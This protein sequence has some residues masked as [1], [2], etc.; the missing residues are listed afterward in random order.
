MGVLCEFNYLKHAVIHDINTLERYD[1]E[2]AEGH[3]LSAI[4]FKNDSE[5]ESAV[6]ADILK[7][8]SRKSDMLF[9]ENDVFVIL[10]PATNKSGAEYTFAQMHEVCTKLE[11]LTTISYPEDAFT[12]D[13]FYG[14]IT[15]AVKAKRG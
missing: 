7:K 6:L 4:V 10:M 11:N 14:K 3:I 8:A 1:D 12:D 9:Y 13:E 2:V 15:E 5:M